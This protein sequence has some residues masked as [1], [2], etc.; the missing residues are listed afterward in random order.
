MD[1][2][3]VKVVCES[4]SFITLVVIPEREQMLL[5]RKV[6]RDRRCLSGDMSDI[7]ETIQRAPILALLALGTEWVDR[8]FK[9]KPYTVSEVRENQ[10]GDLIYIESAIHFE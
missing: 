1:V 10:S 3:R 9:S 6:R 7:E 2:Y 8:K 4:E 5:A